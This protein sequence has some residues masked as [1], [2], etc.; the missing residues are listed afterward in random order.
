[1]M[2]ATTP[3]S[4]LSLI[5]TKLESISYPNQILG[6]GGRWFGP[7]AVPTAGSHDIKGVFDTGQKSPAR[8]VH[9]SLPV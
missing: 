5:L 9:A 6:V 1:M 3:N 8:F 7:A 4:N 2:Q